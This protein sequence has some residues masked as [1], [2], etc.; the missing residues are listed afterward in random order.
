MVAGDGESCIETAV[1]HIGI[2]SESDSSGVGV[3]VSSEES[4]SRGVPGESNICAAGHGSVDGG[5][6]GDGHIMDQNTVA[7]EGK[8]TVGTAVDVGTVGVG[9]GS[10]FLCCN[11]AGIAFCVGIGG[12][13]KVHGTGSVD[14]QDT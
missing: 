4:C 3:G 6:T 11:G 5:K 1:D 7:A 2:G 13:G 12:S 9:D 10:V 8:S 14:G